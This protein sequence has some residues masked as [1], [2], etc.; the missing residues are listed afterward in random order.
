MVAV[1]LTWA[2]VLLLV[3]SGALAWPRLMPFVASRLRALPTAAPNDSFLPAPAPFSTPALLP[4][5]DEGEGEPAAT[6]TPAATVSARSTPTPAPVGYPPTRIVIPAIRLD[7]PVVLTG[8]DVVG[9]G[10]GAQAVWNVP[11]QRAAGW[12]RGS[13]P[14]GVPGNT[15]LNGHNTSNGEVF[16]DLYRLNLGDWI[17]LYS[18]DKSF[19][20]EVIDLL[21]LP[22]AGQPIEVRQ[23]NA[24][25][26]HATDDERVT[27][28][29]CHPYGS[30]RNRLVVIATPAAPIPLPR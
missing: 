9:S 26:I 8:W 11:A 15:V 12:H 14:L 7:A 28:I 30:L 21:V 16:R 4:S 22:E 29:T 10:D 24:R 2:G 5:F 20:Y 23:A 13:A 3:V 1:A 27:L 6:S 17:T 18:G 25:Y 19:T